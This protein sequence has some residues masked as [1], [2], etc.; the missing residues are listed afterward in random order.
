MIESKN[1]AR[2]F[3][4]EATELYDISLDKEYHL[5]L[6]LLINGYEFSLLLLLDGVEDGNFYKIEAAAFLMDSVSNMMMEF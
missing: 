1:K 3:S 4:K 5:D 2:V 6:I